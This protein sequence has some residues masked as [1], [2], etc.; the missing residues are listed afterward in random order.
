MNFL[1]QTALSAKVAAIK[2][3]DRASKQDIDFAQN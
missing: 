3:H 2:G 1:E